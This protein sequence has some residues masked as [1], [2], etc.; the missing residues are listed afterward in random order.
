[1]LEIKGEHDSTTSCSYYKRKIQREHNA[2]HVLL[3]VVG[4]AIRNTHTRT[5]RVIIKQKGKKKERQ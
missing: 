3:F 2:P 1:V 5:K 4:F